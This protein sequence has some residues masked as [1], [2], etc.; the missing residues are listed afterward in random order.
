MFT[1]G[2]NFRL[3]TYRLVSWLKMNNLSSLLLWET[4]NLM[5]QISSVTDT[6]LSFLVD[7][8]I[9]MKPVEIDSAIHKALVVLKMRG[10]DH[11]KNLREFEVSSRGIV[12]T[13]PFS[14]YEGIMSGNARK[15]RLD[16]ATQNF[17][18]AFIRKRK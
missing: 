4:S 18:D 17:T 15:I 9:L 6:G 2:K 5:G 7:A 16:V 14:N 3:E 12:V 11:D 8:I 10:S 13:A 1:E